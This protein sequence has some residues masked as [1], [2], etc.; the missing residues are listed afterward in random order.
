MGASSGRPALLRSFHLSFCSTCAVI[1]SCS[2]HVSSRLSL[3]WRL[4]CQQQGPSKSNLTAEMRHLLT[5]WTDPRSIVTVCT[6]VVFTHTNFRFFFFLTELVRIWMFLKLFP[7]GS[8]LLMLHSFPVEQVCVHMRWVILIG[9]RT[10]SALL[11][12]TK[13]PAFEIWMLHTCVCWELRFLQ[14]GYLFLITAW[15][16][17]AGTK[18]LN[19]VEI[20]SQK[21]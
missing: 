10:V 13:S 3:F 5:P 9:M 2:Q 16:S 21:P 19:S 17:Q 7:E 8:F 6:Y 12:G 11:S 18:R 14:P 15:L 1:S 4:W 20:L